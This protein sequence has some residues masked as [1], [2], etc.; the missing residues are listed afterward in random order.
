MVE[1]CLVENVVPRLPVP[2]FSQIVASR[3][4]FAFVVVRK[5]HQA[6]P[7]ED[8]FTHVF[9]V[10]LKAIHDRAPEF[11]HALSTGEM[12]YFRSLL[13]IIYISLT[14]A[15]KQ[16]KPSSLELGPLVIELLEVVVAKGFKDLATAAHQH[17]DRANPQD[18]ALVT[19]ILQA[20]L[21]INGIGEIHTDLANHLQENETISAATTLFSWSEQLAGGESGDPVYAE[22]SVLFLLELSA[23][24]AI[25]QQ[26]AVDGIL[27]R[28]TSTTL[29]ARIVAHGVTPQTD[30]RLHAI[31]ARGLLPLALN[32][33]ANIGHRFGREIITFLRFFEPQI[34]TAIEGWRKPVVI[35]LP[36]VNE[37]VAIGMLV[38]IVQR[39]GGK[40]ELAQLKFDTAVVA[41]GVDYLLTHRNYL[42]SLVTATNVDEEEM[43]RDESETGLVEKVVVGLETVR[44]LLQDDV[45][46]SEQ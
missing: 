28:L 2:I 7:D 8:L 18:I 1:T 13:R 10:A 44:Q 15:A 37:S 40:Q 23:V 34:G 14:A 41:N 38:A 19:G 6:K 16:P 29:A 5:L 43:L 4:E 3:A 30:P 9:K 26:L 33:L 24:P 32:L 31:W 27:D 20:A 45:E 17:P 42:K 11:H 21:R 46:G 12:D 22:L 39:M 36:A 25:A 35:V